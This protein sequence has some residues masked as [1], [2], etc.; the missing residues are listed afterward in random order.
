MDTRQQESLIFSPSLKKSS[1]TRS[2]PRKTTPSRLYLRQS[3]PSIAASTT[4]HIS[5]GKSFLQRQQLLQDVLNEQEQENESQQQESPEDRTVHSQQQTQKQTEQHAQNDNDKDKDKGKENVIPNVLSDSNKQLAEQPSNPTKIPASAIHARQAQEMS[6]TLA[7]ILDRPLKSSNAR[8]NATDSIPT[9]A[10]ISR[11]LRTTETEYDF[12]PT[13]SNTRLPSTPLRSLYTGT[14]S[15]QPLA[16]KLEKLQ[17]SDEERVASPL[18]R[19][20]RGRLDQIQRGARNV[21]E[22]SN[23]RKGGRHHAGYNAESNLDDNSEREHLQ[24]EVE[25][26]RQND[27]EDE[28]YD[29]H[30]F[31]H[32]FE[33]D[34]GEVSFKKHELSSSSNQSTLVEI[35]DRLPEPRTPLTN[36][37]SEDD[38]ESTLLE[39]AETT[40][41]IT[42]RLRGVYSNL[43]EF[44]SPETEAK[45]NG[46]M[47][48]ISSHKISGKRLS[49][50]S[51]SGSS[52]SIPRPLV[53]ELSPPTQQRSP[54]I[55]KRK[56]SPLRPAV[57]PK[58]SRAQSSSPPQQ[59]QRV[60]KTH[61]YPV[62]VTG[63][64]SNADSARRLSHGS[65]SQCGT[66]PQDAD[67]QETRSSQP[68]EPTSRSPPTAQE[69][70]VLE[71]EVRDSG[72]QERFRR[73][74]DQWRR[75]ELKHQPEA[76]STP[77]YP[78]LFIPSI[79][80]RPATQ[81]ILVPAPIQ[82]PAVPQMDRRVEERPVLEKERQHKERIAEDVRA[83]KAREDDLRAQREDMERRSQLRTHGRS[84][85]QQETI[86]ASR[87]MVYPKSPSIGEKRRRIVSAIEG[88]HR[89]AMTDDTL[90]QLN[91]QTRTT[92]PPSTTRRGDMQGHR[93]RKDDPERHYTRNGIMDADG[94]MQYQRARIAKRRRDYDE[95]ELRF[96]S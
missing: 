43:Q 83:Q 69:P 32:G 29:A 36:N 41:V 42:D 65:K 90:D 62:T 21:S 77:A 26:H 46:A 30:G 96:W 86:S 9:S 23:S 15:K 39:V 18:D 93:Q 75:I 27:P 59:H 47:S 95:E 60:V 25:Q 53:F 82:L 84:M 45:L 24:H 63:L 88:R 52:T 12:S 14:H 11:R 92:Q 72:H 33:H 6:E 35:F 79:Y 89:L 13:R 28:E 57:M 91:I 51:S 68:I 66:S 20:S 44:F 1:R 5:P 48:A 22:W 85:N 34:D 2:S 94:D 37:L 58:Q 61:H 3:F 87:P 4:S 64:I 31:E 54:P 76:L 71:T 55:T 78:D 38:V 17:D 49:L 67:L 80:S 56:P 50:N 8:P 19:H 74:L 7:R 73:K 40:A 10:P 16:E 70:P 81:P